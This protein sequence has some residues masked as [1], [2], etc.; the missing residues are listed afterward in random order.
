MHVPFWECLRDTFH[1]TKSDKEKTFSSDALIPHLSACPYLNFTFCVKFSQLNHFNMYLPAEIRATNTCACDLDM[2]LDFS[3]IMQQW[4]F[5]C[6]RYH[7]QGVSKK[8]VRR[9]F[10]QESRYLLMENSANLHGGAQGPVNAQ[11]VTDDDKSTVETRCLPVVHLPSI[12]ECC[13]TSDVKEDNEEDI[14]K[15]LYRSTT[16]NNAGS[17]EWLGQEPTN[18]E[19]AEWEREKKEYE[20]SE[21]RLV[22][23]MRERYLVLEKMLDEA[24]CQK[25]K[26]E[27]QRKREETKLRLKANVVTCITCTEAAAMCVFIPCFHMVMCEKCADKG[28]LRILRCTNIIVVT[29]P[30]CRGT[31]EVRFIWA[32]LTVR[33]VSEFTR[34]ENV[35][36]LNR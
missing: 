8:C 1:W 10:V 4:V 33:T 25:I 29:C 26:D 18:E 14:F 24:L 36:L 9:V 20:K 19:L 6:P 15:A 2:R 17:K 32:R 28:I 12:N 11:T 7:R 16:L 34:L 31:V 22:D 23:L 35:D 30:S 13:V 5:S 21:A 3:E 27:E